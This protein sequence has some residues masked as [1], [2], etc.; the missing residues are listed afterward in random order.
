MGW[1]A[2]V[3]VFESESKG[4]K[5]IVQHQNLRESKREIIENCSAATYDIYTGYEGRL[6]L[7]CYY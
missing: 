7:F 3:G 6:G 5:F 2:I 4:D 1:A